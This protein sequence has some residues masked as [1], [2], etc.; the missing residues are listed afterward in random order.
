MTTSGDSRCQGTRLDGHPCRAPAFTP[1]PGGQLLCAQHRASQEERS[2]WGRLGAYASSRKRLVE[3]LTAG[4]LQ[5][6]LNLPDLSTTEKVEAFV[7]EVIAEVKVGL[8]A[9][10]LANAIN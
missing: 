10:S 8:L 3:K 1:G 6:H 4:E 7:A 9:P 5:Q 2:A